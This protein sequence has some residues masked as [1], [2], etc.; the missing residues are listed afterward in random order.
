M[1]IKHLKEFVLL[2]EVLSFTEAAELLFIS[3]PALSKHIRSLENE[4]GSPLFDRGRKGLALTRFGSLYLKKAKEIVADYESAE[5]W[6]RDYM[7]KNDRTMLIGLPENLQLYEIND[8]LQMF[9]RIYPDFI[10]ETM[11]SLT[12]SLIR[13][14]EEGVFNIFLTGMRAHEDPSSF[15]FEFLLVKQGRIKACLRKDHP[16]ADRERISAADLENE[17]TVLPLMG[18]L[19]QQFI[20]EWFSDALPDGKEFMYSSYTIAKTL[21]ESGVCVALLQEEAVMGD[22]PES[23]VVRDLDPPIVYNRGIGYDSSKL[24]Q[25][26]KAYLRFVEETMS[27]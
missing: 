21:A 17:K 23:L 26:E 20:E 14:F 22:M 13:M 3:Q 7:K 16:L 5:K 9:S 12:I 6:R 18:T 2:S 24:T 11:E 27:R 19:F 8:H 4:L 10:I 15:T 25:A 1:E